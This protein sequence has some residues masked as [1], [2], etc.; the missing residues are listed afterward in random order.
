MSQ[1]DLSNITLVQDSREQ[2]GYGQLFKTPHVIGALES[3][4]YSVCGL[5]DRIALERKSLP[6]LASSLTHGR[7]RFE[8]EFQRARSLEFF[9]VIVEGRLSDVLEGRFGGHS[10]ANPVAI[11]ESMMS[12]TARY[13]RPFLFCENREIA[14]RTVESL[15]L[16]YCRQFLKTAEDVQRACRRTRK[17]S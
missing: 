16:K 2:L 10:Q 14:A 15:L 3:G 1:L 13:G 9:A 7:E 8:K 17:A 5:E 12:W 6:D 4:D 11:F